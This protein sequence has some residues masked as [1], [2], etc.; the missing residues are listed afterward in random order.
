MPDFLEGFNLTAMGHNTADYL[1]VHI[2]AKKLA[3]ADRASPLFIIQFQCTLAPPPHSHPS[4]LAPT[5]LLLL[6]RC[7]PFHCTAGH[8]HVLT[9]L[10]YHTIAPLSTQHL[11]YRTIALLF[12]HPLPYRNTAPL[13]THLLP[14]Y[15][16]APLSTLPLSYRKTIGLHGLL[17]RPSTTRTRISCTSPWK[18]CS[19]PCNLILICKPYS[20]NAHLEVAQQCVACSRSIPLATTFNVVWCV[21]KLVHVPMA[22][23]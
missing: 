5:F 15:I 19:L 10:P 13:S 8:T 22:G 20:V 16:I 7:L 12:T 1:H 14:Y 3:F 17:C 18:V 23:K 4:A 21:L 2:E 6:L 11:L 9:S